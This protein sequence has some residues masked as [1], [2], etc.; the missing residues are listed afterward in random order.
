MVETNKEQKQE[1]NIDLQKVVM[2]YL[3]ATQRVFDVVNY[4]LASERLLNE[5]EYE[6]YTQRHRV[7]PSQ[8]DAMN[9]ETAKEEANGWILRQTMN[10]LL[11]ILALFLDDCRAIATIA[12]WNAKKITGDL[13]KLLQDERAEF[14][15]M[16][17]AQ[18]IQHLKNKYGIAS[19]VEDHILSIYNTYRT[20]AGKGG[21]VSEAEAVEEGRLVLKL[22]SVLLKSTPSAEGPK[23]GAI[24]VTSE[25]GDVVKKFAAGDKI[26]LS[27]DE[28]VASILTGAFFI[29]SMAESLKKYALQL[30]VLKS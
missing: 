15:K 25:I 8:Q 3:K 16:D 10:E 20:L 28:H 26:K 7:M 1:T 21:V 2:N 9:Y 23:P 19:A 12:T 4:L 11:F 27:K 30:G 6:K 13:Q 24:T 5:E 29:G 14:F 18:R 22:R 17:F